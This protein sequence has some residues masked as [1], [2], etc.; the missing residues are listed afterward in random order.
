MNTTIN[1][2]EDVV[3]QALW[4]DAE[5]IRIVAPGHFQRWDGERYVDTD[6][7]IIA[8]DGALAIIGLRA[9]SENE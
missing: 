7:E 8:T 6:V 5:I 4:V 2:A 9:E 1:M 3:G